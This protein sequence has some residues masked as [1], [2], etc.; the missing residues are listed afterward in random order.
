M[1]YVRYVRKVFQN[2]ANRTRIKKK[3]KSNEFLYRTTCVI[4]LCYE[5]LIVDTN[6]VILA[7]NLI[8]RN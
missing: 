4:L 2:Q 8:G 1:Q 6:Y 7:V 3:K 5:F